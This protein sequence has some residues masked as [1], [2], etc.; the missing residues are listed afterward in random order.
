[1]I[2]ICINVDTRNG[3]DEENSSVGKMFDGCKSKDFLIDGVKNKIKF[4]NEFEKEVIVFIDE[5]SKVPQEILNELRE[6][7]DTVVI[8]KHTHEHNF[9][10]FNYYSCLQL[11]RGEV[12]AHFD[13]DCA[14]FSN[15]TEDVNNLISYLDN[16][17]FVC[18]P[19]RFSPK[20]TID[21]TYNYQWA[22][23][24]FFMCKRDTLDFTEL[25]KCQRN[26]EYFI[27]KY[28]PSRINHWAEHILSL[29]HGN[30]VY[31]PPMTD[32]IT[33]FCWGNYQQGTLKILNESNYEQVKQFVNSR[34]GIH[35]PCELN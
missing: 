23:T 24:R 19:S 22:S 29:V 4:F 32:G 28:R 3:F 20:E 30:S 7:A 21:P 11:A 33:I 26:Y 2:S 1:M 15:S 5:H 6:I 8:R 27:E 34:G 13:Q 31:Y 14:A 18:Y 17:K 10:D 12:I 16:H 25:L 35:Y 9:N